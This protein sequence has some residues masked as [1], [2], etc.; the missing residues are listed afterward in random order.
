MLGLCCC[1]QALSSCSEWGSLSRFG[2][3]ASR[4]RGFFCC[5]GRAVVH[6]AFSSC[7]TRLSCPAASGIFLDQGSNPWP[8]RWQ[9]DSYPLY[10]QGS[11]ASLFL[12]PS[13]YF[14]SLSF[15]A[16]RAMNGAGIWQA[17]YTSPSPFTCFLILHPYHHPMS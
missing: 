7:G 2:A 5:G 6:T 16:F 13:S 9:V 1:V 14:S 12:L 11:P 8:L 10:H 3:Q 15:S 17:L 4:C